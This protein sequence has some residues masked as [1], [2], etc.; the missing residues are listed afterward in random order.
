[1]SHS[2]LQNLIQIL[3]KMPGL[4]PR[5]GRRM[6]LHLLKKKESALKPLI[7]TL[8]NVYD[9]IVECHVCH[10]IDTQSPCKICT[11]PKRNPKKLCIVEGVADLW[12]MER[13]RF[14]D[15]HYHILGG[16][17]SAMDGIGP[18]QLH[19]QSLVDRMT[20]ANVEEVT[21]A[22]SATVDGQT[23]LYYVAELLKPFDVKVTSLAHGVPMGGEL[24]YLDDG[25]LSTAFNARRTLDIAS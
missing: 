22:L 2:E 20:D 17:L 25:T 9:T 6:A 15:G 13:S 8:T 11:D 16:V 3:G 7:D 24:D 10:T 14:Y 1:M 23:T 18:D 5:S 12:A 21:L 4:G 19:L